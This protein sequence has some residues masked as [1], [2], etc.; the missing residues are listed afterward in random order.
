MKKSLLKWAVIFYAIMYSVSLLYIGY[1][2]GEGS[3]NPYPRGAEYFILPVINLIFLG[4]SVYFVREREYLESK[5]YYRM[6]TIALVCGGLT[7]GSRLFFYS[8]GRMTT[9][10]HL[11]IYVYPGI[12]FCL[13]FLI[14]IIYFTC[15]RITRKEAKSE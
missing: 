3:L 12:V 11:D 10:D 2:Y 5:H 14:A 8:Q 4:I 15:A 13:S 9:A 6:G 1:E 7:W